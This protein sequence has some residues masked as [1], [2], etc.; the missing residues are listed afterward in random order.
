MSNDQN[1]RDV[2]T[3]MEHVRVGDIVRFDRAG[4]VTEALCVA[5]SRFPNGGSP[6]VF[7]GD[8]SRGYGVEYVEILGSTPINTP[9]PQRFDGF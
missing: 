7:F 6:D 1:E 9:D 5:V 8:G 3:T 2:W 4:I